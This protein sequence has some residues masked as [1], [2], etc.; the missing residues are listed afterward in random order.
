MFIQN[1]YYLI[2]PSK[3]RDGFSITSRNFKNISLRDFTIS[4]KYSTGNNKKNLWIFSDWQ[5][6][7]TRESPFY[8]RGI[9]KGNIA[10]FRMIVENQAISVLISFFLPDQKPF[11][12]WCV[13]VKNNGSIP[14]WIK[15]IELIRPCG[16][17]QKME[18]NLSNIHKDAICVF[19][20]GWQSWSLSAAYNQKEKQKRSRLGFL[21]NPMIMNP[22]TT[23]T[24]KPSHFSS[25]F[26]SVIND[27]KSKRGILIGFLSQKQQYGSIEVKT[28]NTPIIR[29]WANGD[30]LQLDP[31]TC[32]ETDWAFST[33]ID[34]SSSES[35]KAYLDAVAD[36]HKIKNPSNIPVGWCSW[37]HYYQNIS[38]DIIRKNL[39]YLNTY[40]DDVKFNLFQIDDGFE[41]KVGDWFKFNHRFPNGV[42]LLATEIKNHGLIPG[43]WLAP[44][45]VQRK[46]SILKKFPKWILRDEKN[47]PVNAGFGWNNLS[48][49]LDLTNP[50]AL[51]YVCDVVKK[52][53]Q[54]WGFRYLKLDFLYAAALKG[55]YQ[56]RTKT[57]AQVLRFGMEAIRMA[58]GEDITLLGCGAPL[59]SM[60]GLVDVMRIGADVSGNWQPTFL[61][62]GLPFKDEPS[63]PAARNSIHNIITRANLHKRWWIND[64]DCLLVGAGT[65]LTIPEVQS[66]ATAIA[67]TGGSIILSDDL[68]TLS[69]DR[70]E[71]AKALIPPI[72]KRATVLDWLNE[73]MPKHLRVDIENSTGM[74][75]LLAFFNWESKSKSFYFSPQAFALKN[76]EYW[77]SNFWQRRIGKY[78]DEQSI[79]PINIPSHG[80][81]L[82]AVRKADI[83]KKQY[84]GSS[85]HISQGLEVQDIKTNQ[86]GLYI[87][88]SK[89]HLANGSCWLH[90]NQKIKSVIYRGSPIPWEENGDGIVRLNLE[91]K[92]Q[93]P[94]ELICK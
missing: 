48:T 90:T 28:G 43:L 62:I 70:I 91:L 22:G 82:L 56:D 92:D 88:F 72:G 66:L 94:L 50:E 40:K 63:M 89:E 33:T 8:I 27:K 38:E 71:I 46:S 44:F 2:E 31:A 13:K 54:D 87:Q 67:L 51:K 59:G 64:P 5:A 37:Y 65:N 25:D 17:N 69:M 14:I 75:H 4:I 1:N 83:K 7:D 20:N 11:V 86:S 49:A 68:S 9:G 15:K 19:S 52:A 84:I 81:V 41:S 77:I 58:V 80:V 42:G 26:F 18:S 23:L 10:T 79:S 60:L 24:K 39:H 73:Q 3:R 6:L 32:L 29:M 36:F 76:Q 93:S 55:C 34:T 12:L 45:I 78:S 16:N 35:I 30:N 74:W 61:G 47:R 53:V 21:Q 57:R 85:F